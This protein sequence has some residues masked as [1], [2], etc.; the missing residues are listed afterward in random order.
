M[1][2]NIPPALAAPTENMDPAGHNWEARLRAD[3]EILNHAIVPSLKPVFFLKSTAEPWAPPRPGM[4]KVLKL[5][6]SAL[7][8]ESI[9]PGCSQY[10]H[11]KTGRTSLPVAHGP[12]EKKFF[13]TL[14]ESSGN[15]PAPSQRGD[16]W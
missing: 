14:F 8:E 9:F 3:A 16:Y 7:G 6:R 2:D 1:T 12:G 11:G 13:V 5:P 15:F 4:R 10:R